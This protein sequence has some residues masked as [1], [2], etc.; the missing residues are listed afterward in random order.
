ME[1][2]IE[3]V[4]SKM[5]SQKVKRRTFLK[6]LEGLT[7]PHVGSPAA[8]LFQDHSIR[9]LDWLRGEDFK[10]DVLSKLAECWKLLAQDFFLREKIV[11]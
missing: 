9:A 11:N 4:D 6:R 8:N 5:L 10:G 7:L 3:I 1:Q 2:E